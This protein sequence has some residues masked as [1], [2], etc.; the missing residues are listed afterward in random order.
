MEKIKEYKR[1][2]VNGRNLLFLTIDLGAVN[3]EPVE[4][5]LT[6]RERDVLPLI[7]SGKT[8][9]EIG[10]ALNITARTAKFH[11]AS[12][13]QKTNTKNRTELANRYPL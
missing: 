4:N 13:F 1:R 2:V 8:N 10:N 3:E 11:A 9:K 12:L 7:V 6:M 5:R